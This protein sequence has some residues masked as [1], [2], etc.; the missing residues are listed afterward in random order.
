M[1]KLTLPYEIINSFPLE[2][3]PLNRYALTRQCWN[4]NPQTRPTF[5]EIVFTLENILSADSNQEYLNVI[6]VPYFDD[7]SSIH[8]EEDEDFVDGFRKQ[9]PT[10]YHPFLR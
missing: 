8:S 5:T 3:V 9:P 6:N 7:T 4:W 1:H 10:V 2:I